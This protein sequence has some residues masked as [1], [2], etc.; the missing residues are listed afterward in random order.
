M[1][2]VVLLSTY[3]GTEYVREQLDSILA[4]K[5]EDIDLKILA[6]DDG[7]SDGTQDILE[8]YQEKYAGIFSYEA[9]KNVGVIQSFFKLLDQAPDADYYAFSDQDDVWMK[10]KLQRAVDIMEGKGNANGNGNKNREIP[11]LYACAPTLV[12]P[13]LN[14]ISSKIRRVNIRPSFEN[15]LIENIC[16][17][18]SVV[19]NRKL[20][21]LVRGKTPKNAR[22]HDWWLY[23]VA[24]AFGK[25]YYDET[26]YLY[27][28]QHGENVL[29][30]ATHRGKE[31]KSRLKMQKK[32]QYAN[33]RQAGE[34]VQLYRD[35][36]LKEGSHARYCMGL[37]KRFVVA[38]K[39]FPKRVA[40]LKEGMY[41]QRVGDHWMYKIKI[42]TG[43]Y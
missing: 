3:N 27:Y 18:A 41:R 4:Q 28:R 19:I 22:M 25:V 12:D 7:S 26:S 31:L 42:L 20:R 40:L 8:E 29:G 14:P 38:R 33:S 10:G 21:E 15:A 24:S 2:I 34:F 13:D 37:A 9:G 16:V 30:M 35:V 17:G 11:F 36:P 43:G 6:R 23:L 32:N 1:T 39:S 5:L